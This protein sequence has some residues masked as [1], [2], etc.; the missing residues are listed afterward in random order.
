MHHLSVILLL[1]IWVL[2]ESVA[3]YLKL[4]ARDEALHLGITQQI[5]HLAYG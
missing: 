5:I 1:Q 3:K 4:I 2:F